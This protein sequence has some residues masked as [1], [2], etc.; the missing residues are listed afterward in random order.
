MTAAAWAVLLAAPLAALALLLAKPTLDGVWEDHPAHFWL[1]LLAA[2]A[3]VGLAVVTSD[4][5]RRR[6]DARVLLVSLAFLAGAGF[7][8]LHALATPGV[9]L[10]SP[11]A[12]FV[13]ATPVGL[14]V[15]AA[16]AAASTAEPSPRRS[17]RLVSAAPLLVGLVVLTMGAW[18]AVS[19]ARV[20]PLGEPLP[21]EEAEGWLLGFTLP[22]IALYAYAA[23]RY[24]FLFARRRAHLLLAVVCAYILLA[25]ASLAIALARNWHA[26]WWE[27]HLLMLLAFAIVAMGARREWREERFGDLYLSA[28]RGDVRD[29]SVLFVDLEGFTPFAERA[30]PE[31]SAEVVGE[32][33][34]A[35][36]PLLARRHRGEAKK[37]GDGMMVAFNLHA[38]QPDHARR[39]VRAALALQREARAVSARHPNWPRVRAA[40]NTGAARTGIVAGS[41]EVVGDTV[42]V[43]ARLEGQ[44]PAGG[45]VVGAET[46]RHLPPG[47]VVERLGAVAVKGKSDPV[48]AYVVRALPA[49][50]GDERDE[51]LEGEDRAREHER[52]VGEPRDRGRERRG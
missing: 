18:A 38:D 9:L 4:A 14:L 22:A 11:N 43:G 10:E 52:G 40:V 19:L 35:M 34:G 25:E 31:G 5:A 28:T 17:A 15:A 24:A 51:S 20:G 39:A 8:A 36:V 37:L 50:D 45:V 44:A 47:T 49:H 23:A 27:W 2:L 42:N 46:Y 1:V 3:N 48:E 33:F 6:S 30:G 21:P 7:L 32:Y 29:V 13:V 12:G 16:F 26:T 41:F